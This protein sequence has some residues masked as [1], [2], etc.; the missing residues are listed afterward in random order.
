MF[1][2]DSKPKIKPTILLEELGE[3]IVSVQRKKSN[4][5][6]HL[7]GLTAAVVRFCVG[8]STIRQI[9]RELSDLVNYSITESEVCTILDE[10]KKIGIVEIESPDLQDEFS[11]D[12]KQTSRRDVFKMLGLGSAL[13]IP[14]LLG[15][16]N[17]LSQNKKPGGVSQTPTEDDISKLVKLKDFS[18]SKNFEPVDKGLDK[19]LADIAKESPDKY[20]NPL[21]VESLLQKAGFHLN[22]CLDRLDET[23]R[24]EDLHVRRTFE[25][26]QL[27]NRLA[28]DKKEIELVESEF[29]ELISQAIMSQT[30]LQENPTGRIKG[31][32][33]SV[34]KVRDFEKMS[35]DFDRVRLKVAQN[36]ADKI[37]AKSKLEGNALNYAE[38]YKNLKSLFQIDVKEAFKVMKAAEEGLK[39]VYGIYTPLPKLKPSGYVFE[40]Y[41]WLKQIA[42]EV[43]QIVRSD[44]EFTMSISMFYGLNTFNTE[45]RWLNSDADYKNALNAGRFKFDLKSED[46]P[47]MTKVRLRG[48]NLRVRAND[49]KFS[50]PGISDAWNLILKLPIQKFATDPN[51]SIEIPDLRIDAYTMVNKS[52]KTSSFD[53]HTNGLTNASPFGDWEIQIPG[54]SS[55][56]FSQRSDKDRINDV[57]V[58]LSLAAIGG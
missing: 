10:L 36:F 46:F 22:L 2:L 3:G 56:I 11:S 27:E 43:E 52:E 30:E 33:E 9:I 19:L 28:L 21:E 37:K 5:V 6:I 7:S 39:I 20:Y 17:A 18:G 40:L 51:K 54:H 29:E 34:I 14:L 50:N 45:R 15:A 49:P 23:Q 26:E 1:E 25:L 16:T 35:R 8:T 53:F 58:E 48:V 31:N 32:Q 24:L 55:I 41:S 12:L 47:G 38:R 4:A 44:I 42:N 57:I 13:S